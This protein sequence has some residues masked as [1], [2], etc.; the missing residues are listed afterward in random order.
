DAKVELAVGGAYEWYFS[1]DAPEGQRGSEGCKVL[2]YEP[3][4]MLSF[5]WNAPPKFPYARSQR[6]WVVVHIEPY[7]P[8]SSKVTLKQLGFA[9]QAAK[10]AERAEEWKQVREYFSNAWP[11]VL[12]AL[13]EKFA[14]AKQ[15][16]SRGTG[17]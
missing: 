3:M 7:G 10:G 14:P 6:T 12:G 9:E 15:Q 13:Q 4:S 17:E 5:S 16:G 11:R 1:M 2:S 8:H